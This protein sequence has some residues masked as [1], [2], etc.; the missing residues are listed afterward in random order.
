MVIKKIPQ[1]DS[2]PIPVIY[3]FLEN[4]KEKAI[5]WTLKDYYPVQNE[6]DKYF[7]KKEKYFLKHGFILVNHTIECDKRINKKFIKELNKRIT[8]ITYYTRIKFGQYNKKE[9]KCV[10]AIFVDDNEIENTIKLGYTHKVTGIATNNGFALISDTPRIRFGYYNS[11]LI[12]DLYITLINGTE[13][14]D[15]N[16]V[17]D[18]AWDYKDTHPELRKQLNEDALGLL[19]NK[20]IPCYESIIRNIEHDYEIDILNEFYELIQYYDKKDNEFLQ[21]YINGQP[22]NIKDLLTSFSHGVNPIDQVKNDFEIDMVMK[23]NT[24]IKR[25]TKDV[26]EII[27]ASGL[28]IGNNGEINGYIYGTKGAVEIETISAGGWNIQCF[29]FRVLIKKLKPKK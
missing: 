9:S 4:W 14:S 10:D 3:N 25:I 26:G 12:N 5:E 24:L 29:H 17:M 8:E 20:N 18:F 16:T 27:D 13:T 21:N 7:T 11:R 2:K 22:D 28:R 1:F 6:I 15:V 23:Y 19:E